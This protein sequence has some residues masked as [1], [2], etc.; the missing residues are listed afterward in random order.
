MP[1]S[2]LAHDCLIRDYLASFSIRS[3]EET[4]ASILDIDDKIRSRLAPNDKDN[5]SI[6]R[7]PLQSITVE[8]R[9]PLVS[10]EALGVLWR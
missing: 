6:A 5:Q 4:D 3:I 1:S 7:I 2:I 10:F 9:T 8:T